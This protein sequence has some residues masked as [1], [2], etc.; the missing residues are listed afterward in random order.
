MMDP[1][2]L[3]AATAIGIDVVD[4]RDPRVL[5]GLPKDRT[6]ERVLS[7][8]EAARLSSSADPVRDFWLHWGAKEA[9]FK[10][11]T[12]LRGAPPVFAHAAF[13]VDLEA[14][15]VRYGEIELALVVHATPDR[16]VVVARSV[17]AVE[18][19]TWGAGTVEALHRGVGGLD[20]ERLREGSFSAEERDAVRGLPS[21]LVRLAVRSEAAHCLGVEERRLQVICP[22][23]PTGRRPPYLH[24]DG[25]PGTDIGISISHDGDWLAWAVSVSGS[26][27]GS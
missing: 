18:H 20:V 7:E 23:G 1:G 15:C 16:F 6:V 12:L 19:P 21:A 26:A 24:L 11:V 27:G 25:V 9:A 3:P 5:R 13:E 22:P 8:A 14:E 2:P 10:A 17:E 4:C